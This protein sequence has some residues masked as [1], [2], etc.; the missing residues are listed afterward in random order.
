[1]VEHS[2][3]DKTSAGTR[4]GIL[5]TQQRTESDRL[6]LTPISKYASSGQRYRPTEHSAVTRVRNVT[7]PQRQHTVH[8]LLLR[9]SPRNAPAAK[10]ASTMTRRAL[11]WF[12]RLV[13]CK[14]RSPKTRTRRWRNSIACRAPHCQ[15]SCAFN[16]R[17]TFRHP[18][19]APN[20]RTLTVQRKCAPSFCR[21]SALHGRAPKR[22]KPSSQRSYQAAPRTVFVYCSVLPITTYIALVT[23]KLRT[24]TCKHLSLRFS[25]SYCNTTNSD[26]DLARRQHGPHSTSVIYFRSIL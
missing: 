2:S 7:I 13:I 9:D 23:L 1:M 21:F 3:D 6:Q 4:L 22:R 8:E 5:W 18:E 25:G 14:S 24:A 12:A 26:A 20:A 19:Q 15:I 10:T 16:T 11:L 17:I